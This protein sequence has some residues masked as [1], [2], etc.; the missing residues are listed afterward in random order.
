[1]VL[2]NNLKEILVGLLLGDGNMQTF[3]ITGETWRFRILQG[4]DN[5][6]PYI[7]HLREILDSWTNMDIK[8]Y[9]EVRINDN[10]KIYK[11]WYFNTLSFKQFS[12]LG[13]AFY[14]LKD[15]NSFSN[16]R[17]KVIPYELEYWL[18]DKSLAYWFMDDGS[19]KW[20]NKIKAIR[21]C[22]DSFTESEV[23]LLSNVIYSKFGLKARK[24]LNNKNKWRLYFGTENYEL[25]KK[26]IYSHV[27]PSMLYK[28][29]V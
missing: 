28:F 13:N 17:K 19:N 14:P 21:F 10:N 3:S 1:M 16:I 4:G 20:N 7:S 2:D 25:I 5:H 9:Y 12:E 23:D 11:K 8:E 22:T 6:F 15:S 24:T 26:L 27:I 29:P 18:T